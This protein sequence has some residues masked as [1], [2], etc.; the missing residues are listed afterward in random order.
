[1]DNKGYN[2][3]GRPN[4]RF[5]RRGNFNFV[6]YN[7]TDDKNTQ[8][9]EGVIAGRNAVI[10]LLKSG[11][12]I[13]KLYVK[14]GELE[15]SAKLIVS[16]AAARGIPVIET[17][18]SGLDRL[19]GGSLHQGVVAVAAAK[20][21]VG[22][23]DILQI[24]KERN[25]VPFVV[26]LDGVEDPYNL[27]A[28]IRTAECAGVHGVIIPKRRSAL[29]SSTVEKAS[30]GALEYMAVAKVSNLTFAVDE[31]KKAGLWI[32]AAEADGQAIHKTDMR[33]PAAFVFGSEGGGI[34]PLLRSKCD[35]VVSVDL[36]GKI[37]SLNVSAA[38]AVVLFEAR[39]QR[40]GVR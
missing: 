37:N 16:E 1:M 24:A 38:A 32:Y 39:L 5:D 33:G 40:D 30:A 29:L 28:I 12:C 35:F 19:S 13:D 11:R 10:E 31:L 22:I 23:D 3:S 7:N 34:S 6:R 18:R 9:T 20:E 25:E 17:E 2:R 21:Y 15:G 8:M 4:K 26:I 14:K 27:G 36:K